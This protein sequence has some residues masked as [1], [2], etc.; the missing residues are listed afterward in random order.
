MTTRAMAA[1][2]LEMSKPPGPAS[3]WFGLG[4]VI[5]SVGKAVDEAGRS[6]QMEAGHDEK[7]ASRSCG[8]LLC[9]GRAPTG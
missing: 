3:F 5:R 1:K 4:A 6:L 9:A 7:R 8:S 2:Y